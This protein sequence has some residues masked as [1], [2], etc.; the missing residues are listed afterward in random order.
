MGNDNFSIYIIE[1]RA[2]LDYFIN[3]DTTSITV[4]Y[5][6]VGGIEEKYDKK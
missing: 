2:I 6:N 1:G 3:I 5:L 4:S